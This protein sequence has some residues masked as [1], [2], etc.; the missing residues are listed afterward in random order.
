M[1]SIRSPQA[2]NA[3]ITLFL[4]GILLLA[5]SVPSRAQMSTTGGQAA[6]SRVNSTHTAQVPSG[7]RM[8]VRMIDAIDSDSNNAND[9]FRGVLETDLMSGDTVVAPQGTTVYGRLLTAQST[10]SRAKGE[11]E[12]DITEILINGTLHSLFTTSKQVQGEEGNGVALPAAKGAGVGGAAG[13]VLGAVRDVD[14]NH[15][16][17]GLRALR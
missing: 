9:R 15:Q 3:A 13:A 7:T 12:L 10:G 11:L 16:P 6:P 8:R 4:T 1:I 5:S 2:I 17:C 14:L